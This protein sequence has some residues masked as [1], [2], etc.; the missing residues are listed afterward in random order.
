MGGAE[1]DFREVQL[2]PGVT[3]V[4]LVCV[5]G[6]AE[7]IVPPGMNVDTG[8]FAI[9]GGFG[10]RQGGPALTDPN[11]PV[12]RIDGFALMGGVDLVVRLPGESAKDTKQ[13]ER[14]EQRR[15]KNERRQR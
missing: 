8:G 6:G 10:H 5:M 2:P 3:E 7:V 11:T 15:L 12:L 13:R 14:A 4:T 1:L 9:M